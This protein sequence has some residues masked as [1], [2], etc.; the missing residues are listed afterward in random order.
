MDAAS[1]SPPL[2]SSSNSPPQPSQELSSRSDSIPSRRTDLPNLTQTRGVSAAQRLTRPDVGLNE[3]RSLLEAAQRIAS[4][5]SLGL[6]SGQWVDESLPEPRIR[7]SD[8]LARRVPLTRQ[9]S[10]RPHVPGEDS[11]SEDEDEAE[12]LAQTT[13][14]EETSQEVQHSAEESV[15]NSVLSHE[16]DALNDFVRE[17]VRRRNDNQPQEEVDRLYA[18]LSWDPAPPPP[19]PP[20]PPPRTV[21]QV[22]PDQARETLRRAVA[23]TRDL[24]QHQHARR[25]QSEQPAQ[26]GTHPQSMN[27][28]GRSDHYTTT[29]PLPV[30]D[31][32]YNWAPQSQDE[33]PAESTN[34]T[35]AVS[36]S[37]RRWRPSERLQDYASSHARRESATDSGVEN[38]G[39]T[40][41]PLGWTSVTRP[42]P[43]EFGDHNDIV[44]RVERAL[45]E[46]RMARRAL[47]PEPHDNVP[48]PDTV[49]LG[50]T[51]MATSRVPNYRPSHFR[52]AIDG[53]PQT[54]IAL[55]DAHWSA[56]FGE[57]NTQSDEPMV[58]SAA[59]DRWR[60]DD[61]IRHRIREQARERRR[62]VVNSML[63][64]ESSDLIATGPLFEGSGSSTV[65]GGA[66]SWLTLETTN[67]RNRRLL[68][69]TREVEAE[70]SSK[71]LK[72]AKCALQHLAR[73]REPDM[74]PEKAWKQA[75]ELGLHNQSLYEESNNKLAMS[76][77]DLPR[78][79]HC[80]WLEPGMIWSGTQSADDT[81]DHLVASR[82]NAE[83]DALRRYR[84]QRER[85]ETVAHQNDGLRMRL[86]EGRDPLERALSVARNS[87]AVLEDAERDLNSMLER[88]EQLLAE[89][90]ES[91][92]ESREILRQQLRETDERL[93]RIESDST[94]DPVNSQIDTIRKI[95]DHWDVKVTLHS[96]DWD[97]MT[98]T[99]TMTAGHRRNSATQASDGEISAMDSFFT[100]EIIDFATHGLDTL[101]STERKSTS[102]DGDLYRNKHIQDDW[103]IGG[104]ET[105]L[106]YW[107]GIGPF[108]KE[109]GRVLSERE[110]SIADC[111]HQHEMDRLLPDVPSS[112]DNEQE[113][114]Q[115][116][117]PDSEQKE[118]LP[119]IT[120][121]ST[122]AHL[123]R[124]LEDEKHDLKMR[125]MHGLLSDKDWLNKHINSQ[126]WIL[127]RWKELCFVSPGAGPNPE[128]SRPWI[129]NQPASAAT[130]TS[131]GLFRSQDPPS[132]PSNPRSAGLYRRR[133]NERNSQRIYTTNAAERDEITSST[134]VTSG[135]I[136]SR[137]ATWGLTI[138]GFYYVAL[139]R[140]TGQIEALYYDCG[141]A[142][143][144]RLKMGPLLTMSMALEDEG[145]T[146]RKTDDE[147]LL[148]DKVGLREIQPAMSGL[149]TNF[150]V[151]EFR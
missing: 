79:L 150:N 5:A 105:D 26:S 141:S 115:P 13:I 94:P 48:R 131:R 106:A 124:L 143:F 142:P 36:H 112:I 9:Y 78:P 3:F 40:N 29:G 93:R 27:N 136:G 149:R 95:K 89:S 120:K 88:S 53:L 61:S 73:L 97:K 101:S 8:G 71:D 51:E 49:R 15:Q 109:V 43:R 133:Q 17:N 41:P 10:G 24:Q 96:T 121:A 128:P 32:F 86:R 55:A 2:P 110:A 18:G 91:R 72:Q 137:Q 75:A 46:Y 21:A 145:L 85:V 64:Q 57:A 108:K 11:G 113:T 23:I 25:L 66:D 130:D 118:S 138:S 22:R 90:N 30:R 52:S 146:S 76:L 4:S 28:N 38:L 102:N 16:M 1:G 77:D 39:P 139:N 35:T 123:A 34:E 50:T 19:P 6:D 45:Q 68:G 134:G 67:D 7:R 127:M 107:S 122:S 126:G 69:K 99:G 117:N 87:M 65:N 60:R 56:R 37:A 70:I 92:Y 31:S 140:Q 147:M 63:E 144:Q 44:D 129:P 83:V 151:V 148:D 104:P 125:T 116:T 135:G 14:M 100:G 59:N 132:D 111:T 74:K 103:K 33:D 58:R 80:S 62:R 42:A 119:A 20:P 98:V 47:R 81:K 12:G 114:A 82:T 54:D 84:E